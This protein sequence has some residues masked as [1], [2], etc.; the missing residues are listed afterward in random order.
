MYELSL[1]YIYN[2]YACI[3]NRIIN[4]TVL[5]LIS[6]FPYSFKYS[7]S[8]KCTFFIDTMEFIFLIFLRYR[9][10]CQIYILFN[11]SLKWLR[12]KFQKYAYIT[13]KVRI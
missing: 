12:K 10:N 5:S 2:I 7:V 8:T 4:Y 6:I 13:A 1:I 11:I 3:C 9:E